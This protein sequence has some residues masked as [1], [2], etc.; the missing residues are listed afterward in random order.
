M[1]IEVAG[2]SAPMKY[3]TAGPRPVKEAPIMNMDI[4]AIINVGGAQMNIAMPI[5]LNTNSTGT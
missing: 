2:V 4:A 3:V 5:T 1:G